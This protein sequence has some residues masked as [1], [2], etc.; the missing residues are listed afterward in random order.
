MVRGINQEAGEKN[1]PTS[2]RELFV[3]PDPIDFYIDCRLHEIDEWISTT[4]SIE[5]KLV[6]EISSA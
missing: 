2:I 4:Y 1:I 6:D 5:P 3:P